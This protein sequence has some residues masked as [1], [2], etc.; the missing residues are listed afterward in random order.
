MLPSRTSHAAG[1]QLTL[2]HNVRE[3]SEL[4]FSF[5]ETGHVSS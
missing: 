5:D 3:V 2:H 1:R 4:M